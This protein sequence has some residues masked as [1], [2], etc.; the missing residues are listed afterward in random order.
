MQLKRTTWILLLVAALM[1]GAVYLYEGVGLKQR[2]ERESVAKRVLP[3]KSEAEVT[4]LTVKTAQYTLTVSRSGSLPPATPT[5]GSPTASPTPTSG[6]PAAPTPTAGKWTVA[7]ESPQKAASKP[8]NEATV[9]FLVNLLA[10]SD[11]QAVSSDKDAKTVITIPSTQKADFGLAQPSGTLDIQLQDGK[12]H[13][14]IL[15]QPNFNNSALYA[16][17]DP[18]ASGSSEE[19]VILVPINFQSAL[20]RSLSEW[21]PA[22]ASATT[23]P[24][25]QK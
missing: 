10:S 6:S 22:S 15:G 16:Q 11:R 5:S 25:A 12:T 7:V 19:Q 13:Q 3:I 8:A 20:Q 21:Y 14:L 24:P 9:D 17:L 2:E 18:P 4:A 1:G 23:S